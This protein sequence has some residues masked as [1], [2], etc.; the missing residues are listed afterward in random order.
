MT[1]DYGT[2]T[3]FFEFIAAN[4]SDYWIPT[5]AMTGLNAAQTLTYEYTYDLPATW[6]GA[7]VWTP[8]VSGTTQIETDE[9]ST[10]NGISVFVRVT[11]DNNTYEN[12]TPG[13]TATM[14][15]D[16][17]NAVAQWD[18]VNATCVDPDAADGN[19]IALQ[20]ITERPTLTPALGTWE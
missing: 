18:V 11:V 7:T 9:I 13:Q 14:T 8:L 10:E 4:F 20:T 2:D 1:Y 15:L 6:D 3:L 17:Q 12:L 19:D 5:F 16:G